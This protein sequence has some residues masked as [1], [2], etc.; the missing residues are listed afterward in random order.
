MYCFV[1]VACGGKFSD[2]TGQIAS[3]AYPR[4]YPT[5]VECVWEL[6]A[7]PG[8]QLILTVEKMG[9]ESSDK[10]NEDYLEIRENSIS[11]KLIGSGHDFLQ[12]RY[13]SVSMVDI[14]FQVSI[15]ETTFHLIYHKWNGF[16]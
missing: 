9:I 2:K 13:D 5:D 3:P 1:N 15:V 12:T 4:S 11:G 6:I 8:N 10:C 16:G 7:S 14:F